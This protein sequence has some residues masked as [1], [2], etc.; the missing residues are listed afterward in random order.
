MEKKATQRASV[1]VCIPGNITPW[2]L[3]V[4]ECMEKSDEPIICKLLRGNSNLSI[5]TGE[6]SG[7]LS[8]LVSALFISYLLSLTKYDSRV[9]SYRRYLKR[10]SVFLFPLPYLKGLPPVNHTVTHRKEATS[11]KLNSIV[12]KQNKIT[13]S[14]KYVEFLTV[15]YKCCSSH[16]QIKDIS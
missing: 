6:Y 8:L 16:P 9:P 11:L 5:S 7:L 2:L 1:T 14:E 15:S 3:S 10:V 4:W 13:E 12:A